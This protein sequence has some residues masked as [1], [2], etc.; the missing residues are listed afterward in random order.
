MTEQERT[1]RLK[2]LTTE[3]WQCIKNEHTGGWGKARRVAL[4][5]QEELFRADGYGSMREWARKQNFPPS[6]SNASMYN[7]LRVGEFLLSLPE[8]E[9]KEWEQVP[10][11]SVFGVLKLLASNDGPALILDHL[12]KGATGSGLKQIMAGKL[13]DEHLEKEW[14]TFTLKH[15]CKDHYDQLMRAKNMIKYVAGNDEKT[16]DDLIALGFARAVLNGEPVQ[17][18][19][20]WADDARKSF[21]EDVEMGRYVGPLVL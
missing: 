11:S 14:R 6:F 13:P 16:P 9:Q 4:V 20:E 7:H 19:G 2:Q 17:T 1:E 15:V 3:L 5:K 8:N 18:P 10:I 12:Q 21:V